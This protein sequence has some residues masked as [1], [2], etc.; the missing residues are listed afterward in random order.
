MSAFFSLND[1]SFSHFYSFWLERNFIRKDIF[2]LGD[3]CSCLYY[4]IFWLIKIT[5]KRNFFKKWFQWK[6]FFLIFSKVYCYSLYLYLFYYSLSL[7]CKSFTSFLRMAKMRSQLD[8][9]RIFYFLIS[10][11][12]FFLY[13]W[14]KNKIHTI[15]QKDFS[16]CCRSSDM[17]AFLCNLLKNL[18]VW[19]YRQ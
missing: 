2:R 10:C 4:S 16:F 3:H 17:Y 11:L 5:N 19:Y 8:G 1:S 12:Y 13:F 18:S 7:F 9:D 15:F 14:R 6:Y